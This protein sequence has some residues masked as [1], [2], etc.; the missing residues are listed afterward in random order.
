MIHGGRSGYRIPPA[1]ARSVCEAVLRFASQ[2]VR[3]DQ[4]FDGSGHESGLRLLGTY[5]E[6]LVVDLHGGFNGTSVML[7]MARY[8]GT[9]IVSIKEHLRAKIGKVPHYRRRSVGSS[10]L[11]LV[12]YTDLQR[13]TGHPVGQDIAAKAVQAIREALAG[14]GHNSFDTVWWFYRYNG[15]ELLD[16]VPHQRKQ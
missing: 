15:G 4:P 14:D 10:P 8:G 6:R 1:R 11:W 13:P 16:V 3:I 5:C 2:C 9:D 7:S 12:Y